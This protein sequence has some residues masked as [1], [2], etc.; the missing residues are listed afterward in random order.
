[1]E[2]YDTGLSNTIFVFVRSCVVVEKNTCKAKST[3]H[4]DS[5]LSHCTYESPVQYPRGHVSSEIDSEML[6]RRRIGTGVS[7]VK[8]CCVRSGHC[9]HI[10]DSIDIVRQMA[11]MRTRLRLHEVCHEPLASS[12]AGRATFGVVRVGS[13]QV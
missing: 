13:F 9:W 1:M 8:F 7:R 5:F 6:T 2:S 12:L 4:V 10:Y 11:T 3:N